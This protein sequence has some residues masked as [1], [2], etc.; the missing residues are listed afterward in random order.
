MAEPATSLSPMFDGLPVTLYAE[1]AGGTGAIGSVRLSLNGGSDQLENVEPYALFGDTNGDF[2]G[3]A[4]LQIGTNTLTVT[5]YSGGNGSGSVLEVAEFTFT[6][7]A[8]LIVGCDL[9]A[10]LPVRP[11]GEGRP[12]ASPCRPIVAAGVLSSQGRNISG[13]GSRARGRVA[14]RQAFSTHSQT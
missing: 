5:T 2:T 13:R 3:D 11:P 6:V 9:T 4:D 7:E 14:M 10:A 1:R 12:P 8:D